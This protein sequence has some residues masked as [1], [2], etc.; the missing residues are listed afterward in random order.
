MYC[1]T[2]LEFFF[3]YIGR[4]IGFLNHQI[5]VNLNGL[6]RNKNVVLTWPPISSD[7]LGAMAAKE[8]VLLGARTTDGPRVFPWVSTMAWPPAAFPSD[9]RV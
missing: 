3:K 8:L 4:Y 6:E 9:R 1:Y 2:F 5:F 7:W